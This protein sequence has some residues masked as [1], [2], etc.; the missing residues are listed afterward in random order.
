M[1]TLAWWTT[2]GGAGLD[3]HGANVFCLRDWDGQ[4]EVAKKVGAGRWNL[5]RGCHS[6]DEI[7]WA[8]L[9]VL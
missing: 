4:D 5:H 8:E 9:P 7:W 1:R 3:F 6:Q 2:R